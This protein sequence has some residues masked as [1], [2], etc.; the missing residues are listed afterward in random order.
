MGAAQLARKEHC[1]SDAHG[2]LVET[3]RLSQQSGER[4]NLVRALTALGQIER[5]QGRGDAVR[6]LYDQP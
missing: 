4:R 6:P 1:P 3:V 5:D 2:D